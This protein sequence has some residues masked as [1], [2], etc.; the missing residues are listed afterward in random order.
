MSWISVALIQ[1]LGAGYA[2]SWQAV[3]VIDRDE[4]FVGRTVTSAGLCERCVHARRVTSSRASVFY[5]CRLSATDPT[6]AKY[7]RLPVL[8]CSGFRDIDGPIDG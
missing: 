8:H 6:F 5:M 4:P 3:Q 2:D 1:R 7:P